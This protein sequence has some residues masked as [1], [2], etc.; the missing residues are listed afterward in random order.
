MIYITGDLHGDISR[1]KNRALKKL[2]KNDTLIV[3][4]DFGFMWDMSD[5]ETKKM[6]FL[7]SQKYN[8]LFVDGTHENFDAIESCPVV[9]FCAG[10][11][12]KIAPN[13]YH[14]M[15][16][17]IFEIEGKFIFA[18]GG[19]VSP[20]LEQM[21][22]RGSWSERELP[23]DEEMQHAVDNLKKF[24]CE[25]DYIITHEANA[26]HKHKIWRNCKTNPVN[27]FLEQLCA[28]VR[29]EKWF[30]G[31]LHADFALSDT[32]FS[33]FEEVVQAD[34]KKKSRTF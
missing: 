32:I 3:C 13:I 4:G 20:D 14:L 9:D 10:K 15:R 34:A 6:D 28:E 1:F 27:L 18:F 12:H 30:F 24:N 33:V 23:T 19:G 21:I 16:G 2:T 29:F 31:N 25:V 11:A 8:I 22:D 17:E 5:A 26:T 7:K